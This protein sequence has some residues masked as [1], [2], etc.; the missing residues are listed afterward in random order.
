MA[1]QSKKQFGVYPRP[2]RLLLVSKD[3]PYAG[4]L[5]LTVERRLLLPMVHVSS[6]RVAALMLEA[7]RKVDLIAVDGLL[8]QHILSEVTSF[9]ESYPVSIIVLSDQS[10]LPEHRRRMAVLNRADTEGLISA[11]V[12]GLTVGF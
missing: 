8:S 12:Y 2:I 1:D 7:G 10:Q 9:L 11:I 3:G 4:R 5:T 6:L